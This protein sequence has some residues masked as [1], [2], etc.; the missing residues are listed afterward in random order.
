[1]VDPNYPNAETQL[2]NVQEAARS[3]GL[4]IR[5]V[6]A[7]NEREIDSAFASLIQK[8]ADALIILTWPSR[9]SLQ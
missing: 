1:L 9:S 7:T 3:V 6:K 5:V 2:R 8:R 4:Q